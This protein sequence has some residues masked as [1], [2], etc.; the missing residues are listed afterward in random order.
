MIGIGLRSGPNPVQIGPESIS[1]HRSLLS[2]KTA[3]NNWPMAS[4]MWEMS[5][6]YTFK[7]PNT[8]RYRDMYTWFGIW[9]WM[10]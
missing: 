2:P 4:F 9:A 8:L 6:R 1:G 5:V 7:L 10:G 3:A